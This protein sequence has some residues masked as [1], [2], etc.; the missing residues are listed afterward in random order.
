MT[1]GGLVSPLPEGAG[2]VGLLSSDEFLDAAIPFDT[3]LFQDRP[4]RRVGVVLCAD[5]AAAPQ[6][7]GFARKHFAALGATVVDV[8]AAC[9]TGTLPDVDALYLAG[10]NPR[11]LLACVRER[12][13]W[14][15]QVLDRWRDGMTLAGA[16]AGAM[17]LCRQAIGTC[18]CDNPSHEWG[19]GLGPLEGIGLAVHAD[20][21][22]PAWLD[23]LG[24]RAP[25]PVLAIDEATGVV[26]EAGREPVV[27]GPGRAWVLPR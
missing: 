13:G 5:H 15:E 6:S 18:T 16:S 12:S 25:V 22:D 19:D 10:G 17:A 8:P 20:R 11:E 27:A 9:G 14:W 23:E 1:L 4:V 26:L 3:E 7:L 21:R 2:R 24:R